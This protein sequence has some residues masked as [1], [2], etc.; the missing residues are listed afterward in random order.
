MA[1]AT[2]T[3]K[4]QITIPKEVRDALCLRTGSQV[5]FEA[6]ADGGYRLRA[7]GGERGLLDLAGCISYAGPPV[8]LDEMEE[9]IAEGALGQ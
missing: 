6:D 5:I 8:T 4:G 3:S 7:A 1:T 2:L 9:A